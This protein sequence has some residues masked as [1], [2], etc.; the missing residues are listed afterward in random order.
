MKYYCSPAMVCERRMDPA[1]CPHPIPYP[2]PMHIDYY[3]ICPQ[4]PTEAIKSDT[5]LMKWCLRFIGEKE[6]LVARM[7]GVASLPH[8][9]VP[10]D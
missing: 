7:S 6:L 1:R 9:I 3:T 5:F 2:G 8:V 10:G 4:T